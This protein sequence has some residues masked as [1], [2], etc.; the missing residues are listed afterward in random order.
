M[1]TAN[2]GTIFLPLAFFCFL[3]STVSPEE[4][5]L[6]PDLLPRFCF[7]CPKASTSRSPSAQG[8]T[9][10]NSWSSSAMGR[11]ATTLGAGGGGAT[12][13]QAPTLTS[14][15][16]KPDDV[17]GDE[18]PIVGHSSC[19]GLAVT[20]EYRVPMLA[21][22]MEMGIDPRGAGKL[23]SKPHWKQIISLGQVNISYGLTVGNSWVEFR[24]ILAALATSLPIWRSLISLMCCSRLRS[25]RSRRCRSRLRWSR[26]SA[27]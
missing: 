20:L 11:L 1:P 18:L 27:S 2:R 19:L 23:S 16:S 24:L 15:A 4:V 12:R 14:G 21:C 17:L 6:V 5:A 3:L 9:A 25:S 10:R 7:C 13:P 22:S 26:S 8:P